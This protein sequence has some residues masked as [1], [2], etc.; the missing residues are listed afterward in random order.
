MLGK[1][2]SA[3]LGIVE[4]IL[5]GFASVAEAVVGLQ[6]MPL[7]SAVSVL[8]NVLINAVCELMEMVGGAT[9]KVLAIDIGSGTSLF[10]VF[11]GKIDWIF[12]YM[13]TISWTFILLFMFS[14]LVH[15][16][17]SPN[18]DETPLQI[19]GCS[20]LACVFTIGAP[21]FIIAFEKVF[22]SFYSVIV[23][24]FFAE[25]LSFGGF[26]SAATDYIRG[27]GLENFFGK[28]MSAMIGCFLLL[29][30]VVAIA[31]EFIKLTM[32]IIQRYVVLGVLLM[33]SPLACCLF[34]TKSTRR[35][36]YAWIKM[37]ASALLLLTLNV[38]FLG[39]FFEALSSFSTNIATMQSMAPNAGTGVG[40]LTLVF[41]YTMLLLGV[42]HIGET[43][44]SFMGTL[45]ISTAETGSAMTASLMHM[46]S[47]GI[48][49][50]KGIMS[51]HRPIVSAASS[52]RNRIDKHN[53]KVE[54]KREE[55]GVAGRKVP[56]H[57]TKDESTRHLDFATPN[58][59]ATAESINNAVL[60]VAKNTTIKGG[61][62]GQTVKTE[63]KGAP[64]KFMSQL[65]ANSCK[66]SNGA[67]TMSTIKDA[68]GK[69]ATVTFVPK[70][71]AEHFGWKGGR[72]VTMAGQEYVGFASGARKAE[73]LYDNPAA[74]KEL[75][76]RYGEGNVKQLQ[77]NG[78]RSGVFRVITT[79]NNDRHRVTEWAPASGYDP[80]AGLDAQKVKLG[81][82]AYWKYQI[83]L[84]ME[85]SFPWEEDHLVYRCATPPPD[86]AHSKDAQ[87]WF[88]K[89]FSAV[90]RLGYSYAG[91]DGDNIFIEQGNEKYLMSPVA[92]TIV[93]DKDPDH[94]TVIQR[95][96]ASNG[97]EYFV[98]RVDNFKKETIDAITEQRKGSDLQ[99]PFARQI[100]MEEGPFTSNIHGPNLVETAINEQR[101][102]KKKK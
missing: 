66:L 22:N 88:K 47:T 89:Q 17:S 15:C 71:D 11:F 36:F 57:G 49:R 80:D 26:A 93:K 84:P 65:D 87:T 94:K 24:K 102:K 75:C 74:R 44:D 8:L 92:S 6:L 30:V 34:A 58:G 3:I 60:Q 72:P 32:E 95:E 14:A 4:D 42:L 7:V 45:G 12:P 23:S 91:H 56:L 101:S 31:I 40:E 1:I 82:Q 90:N 29:V 13:R 96:P 27:G 53:A 35:S 83:T 2:F 52:V 86:D 68:Q 76:E 64:S 67:I 25:D 62:V 38:L 28:Q 69:S 63:M 51:G 99:S 33:T 79:G 5:G 9:V 77:V 98:L 54:R 46:I 100:T 21:I 70:E 16:L 39:V 55:A 43:I 50:P 19:I 73:F 59:T 81:G 18:A 85:H 78:D 41:A 48:I 97:A 10:E 20:A 61:R 37:V